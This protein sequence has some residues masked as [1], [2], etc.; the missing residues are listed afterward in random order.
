MS[1]YYVKTV[2][3]VK[4]ARANILC[5]GAGE[6]THGIRSVW[7]QTVTLCFRYTVRSLF[8]DNIKLD[9]ALFLHCV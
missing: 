7:R 5:V 9:S 3:D 2:F 1:V 6:M 8:S 4:A